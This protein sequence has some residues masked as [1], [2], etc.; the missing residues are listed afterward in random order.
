MGM[1]S[2]GGGGFEDEKGMIVQ[3]MTG[4]RWKRM[5]GRKGFIILLLLEKDLLL[6]VSVTCMTV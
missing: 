4:D 1:G 6:K 3:V 5:S 2:L